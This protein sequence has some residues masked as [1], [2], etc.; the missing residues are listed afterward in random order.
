MREHVVQLARD[1]AALGD[2]R[3]ARLLIA[4]VLEL[5]EQQLRLDPGSRANASRTARPPPTTPSPTSTPPQP[6]TNLRR[7]PSRL[8]SPI[9]TAPPT[10]TPALNG[11]RVSAMNTA[12]PA[13]TPV[14]PFSCSPAI[15]TPAAPITAITAP[16]TSSGR[17]GKPS[18]IAI[19]SI[20]ANTMQRERHRQR[21]AVQSG[22]G[23]AVGAPEHHD[24]RSP[25]SRA[26]A[27][28]VADDA[29]APETGPEPPRPARCPALA[30][31]RSPRCGR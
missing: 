25:P 15:A 5:G 27:A 29:G 16:W 8:P 23:M 3:R 19:R 20:A 6:R 7:A 12:T 18:R 30:V 21:L 31:N 24:E 1:P 17:S 2:S 13:A 11:S 22:N 4:R 26:A 14:A 28:T 10:A 9:V